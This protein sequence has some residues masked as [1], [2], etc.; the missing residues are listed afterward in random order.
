MDATWLTFV[1]LLAFAVTMT[2]G[3][4]AAVIYLDRYRKLRGARIVTCPETRR[5]VT[6]NVNAA[7]GATRA[8]AGGTEI[9]LKECTRWPER[10]DCGQE[11]LLQVHAEGPACLVQNI[12]RKNYDGRECV[13]CGRLFRDLHPLDHPPGLRIPGSLP[14]QWSSMRPEELPE[15]FE[16]HDL[17]CWDCLI[18]ESF[19]IDHPDLVTERPIQ[20]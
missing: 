18:A 20:K 9:D 2:V 7:R 6:V 15:A 16:T 5:P 10:Q 17:V 11:C 4:P 19:R 8:L 13:Y 1:I 14:I 3:L 12:V